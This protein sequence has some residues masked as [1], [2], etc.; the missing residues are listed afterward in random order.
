MATTLIVNPGSTS[1]KYALYKNGVCIS[2]LFFEETGLGFSMSVVRNGIKIESEEL[3]VTHFNRSF[4]YAVSYLVREGDIENEVDITDIGLRVVSPGT[5]F[6]TH[7]VIDASYVAK[8]EE[9]ESVAP[10]HIP[11]VLTEISVAQK[12][13]PKARLIGISDSAFHVTI[14]EH[15]SAVSV[16]RAD[17]LQYDIK[18]F[19]YHGLSF[20]SISRRL[21]TQF[22][23]VPKR[24]IVCH[25]GGGV[26]ICALKN[27]VSVGTSMGYSPVSG[28]IMGSRGGDI[29]AGVVAALTVRKN[30]RGK[31]LYDYLYTQTGFQ[32]VA[33][34]KDLRLVMERA[35]AKDVHAQLALDMFVHQVRSWIGIH[36]MQL[37][38][39][40]AI[41]LT[42][43]A[44]ERNP[45]VRSLIL[46]ELPLLEAWLDEEKNECLIGRE[47]SIHALDSNV[48][49]AVMKTDE[50]GEMERI[51][52]EIK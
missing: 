13:L 37:G 34:V 2:I 7:R 11:G 10:L 14:P 40:D 36:A 22:G 42:A 23:R 8:L 4:A 26:S 51:A 20:A 19:G 6:T 30:L 35:A 15:V 12:T 52:H 25:I 5:Y 46:S 41:V 43:T 28:V 50:M 24:V 21:K 32:G 3:S 18:R 17:A 1:R 48:Q 9:M 45:K 29:T 33:G 27:G 31:E 47:G 16:P 44:S 39:V 38:G 49:I